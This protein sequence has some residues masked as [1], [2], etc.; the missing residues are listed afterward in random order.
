MHT[1]IEYYHCENENEKL[2]LEMKRQKLRIKK[3]ENVGWSSGS[4]AV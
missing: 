4:K 1:R 3:K 2:E